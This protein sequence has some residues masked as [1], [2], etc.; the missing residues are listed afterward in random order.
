M[1]GQ[2]KV[3]SIGFFP[4]TIRSERGHSLYFEFAMDDVSSSYENNL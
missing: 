2:R 1:E 4:Q 3:R